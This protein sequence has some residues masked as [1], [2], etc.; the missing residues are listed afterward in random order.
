MIALSSTSTT[1][2]LNDLG[3]ISDPDAAVAEFLAGILDPSQLNATA[4]QQAN[5]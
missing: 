5:I 4:T 1:W 3:R 2:A